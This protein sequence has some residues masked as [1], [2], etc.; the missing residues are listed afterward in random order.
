M[1]SPAWRSRNRTTAAPPSACRSPCAAARTRSGAARRPD[2]S[3]PARTMPAS[4]RC[5]RRR[6]VRPMKMP[7]RR[8]RGPPR[9]GCAPPRD[10]RCRNPPGRGAQRPRAHQA[11]SRSSCRRPRRSV[12]NAASRRRADQFGRGCTSPIRLRRPRRQRPMAARSAPSAN[13]APDTLGQCRRARNRPAAPV[14]RHR[15]A[16]SPCRRR[17][18]VRGRLTVTNAGVEGDRDPRALARRHA[19][20]PRQKM[21]APQVAPKLSHEVTIPRR[22]TVQ[23]LANRT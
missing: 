1:S 12:A 13:S 7:R 15:S 5:A 21:G 10:S 4:V 22:S 19:P 17:G 6:P 14:P 18:N 9:R 23:E 8:R 11:T 2:R 16:R 3:P 20:P